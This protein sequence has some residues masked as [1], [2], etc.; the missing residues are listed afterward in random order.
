MVVGCDSDLRRGEAS[1]SER[2]RAS[3]GASFGALLALSESARGRAV[4]V[5]VVVVVVMGR[6]VVGVVGVSTE[7]RRVLSEPWPRTSKST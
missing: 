3:N 6:G 1:E 7:S 2:G 5:A 4:V